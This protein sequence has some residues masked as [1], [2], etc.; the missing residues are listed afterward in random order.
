MA[1]SSA[2]IH[3]GIEYVRNRGGDDLVS[4]LLSGVDIDYSP[5]ALLRGRI[6]HADARRIVENIFDIFGEKEFY[7]MGK[8]FISFYNEHKEFDEYFPF[9]ST[10]RILPS[11]SKMD[12][13]TFTIIMGI[14]SQIN[15]AHDFKM[16]KFES[17]YAELS[18]KKNPRHECEGVN[19]R[20]SDSKFVDLVCKQH[21]GG[22]EETLKILK[23]EEAKVEEIFHQ[24]IRDDGVE[25]PHCLYRLFWK[26]NYDER[27]VE[28]KVPYNMPKLPEFW[29]LCGKKGIEIHDLKAVSMWTEGYS[30]KKIAEIEHVSNFAIKSRIKKLRKIFNVKTINELVQLFRDRGYFRTLEYVG[31]KNKK[32][33]KKK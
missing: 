32:D 9:I 26:S 33:K 24:G 4:R 3:H 6:N 7:F 17:G 23:A 29:K 1:V 13:Q 18:F 20:M 28:I 8:D 15:S 10:M 30:Y 27:A 31:L 2:L 19:F 16:V 21:L 22:L 25:I 11:M 12:R 5:P 14:G